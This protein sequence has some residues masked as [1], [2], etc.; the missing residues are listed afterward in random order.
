MLSQDQVAGGAPGQT[1]VQR[2]QE[3]STWKQGMSQHQIYGWARG[4]ESK[5]DMI[6]AL[7]QI[8]RLSESFPSRVVCI[9]LLQNILVFS[10]TCRLNPWSYSNPKHATPMQATAVRSFSSRSAHMIH[11]NSQK[12]CGYFPGNWILCPALQSRCHSVLCRGMQLY[13]CPQF[14][15]IECPHLLFPPCT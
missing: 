1:Q 14:L 10:R 15:H 6:P 12:W 5:M 13:P 8:L 3:T 2:G 4:Q 11:S 7:E 9:M